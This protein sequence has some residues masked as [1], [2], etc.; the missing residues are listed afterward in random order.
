MDQYKTQYNN[1]IK[2]VEGSKDQLVQHGGYDLIV[3]EDFYDIFLEKLKGLENLKEEHEE[4]KDDMSYEDYVHAYILKQLA[5]N[6]EANYII[7]Y[8]RFM[9]ASY[10]KENAILYEDF[11]GGDIAGFCTREIEQVDVECDHI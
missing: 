1:L 9:A 2:I 10:I 3:I 4:C 6:D 5:N 11:L 8:L 7:M